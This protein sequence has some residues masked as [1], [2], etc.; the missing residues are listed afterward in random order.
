MSPIWFYLLNDTERGLDLTSWLYN[1]KKN[2][3]RLNN[4]ISYYL[5][6]I[7]ALL[8]LRSSIRYIASFVWNIEYVRKPKKMKEAEKRPYRLKRLI[9]RN[10]LKYLSRIYKLNYLCRSH[11]PLLDRRKTRRKQLEQYGARR[12]SLNYL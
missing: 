5:T 12:S 11:R 4:I 7:V 9:T 6:I 1:Y 8:L 10:L 2:S 3:S